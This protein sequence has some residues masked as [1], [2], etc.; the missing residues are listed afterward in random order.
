MN[1]M[2]VIRKQKKM[3][4]KQLGKEVGVSESTISLY[5]NGKHEPDLIT[6]GRIADVLGVSVD[7]LLGRDETQSKEDEKFYL[8]SDEY[9]LIQCYRA[10][11]PEG[12][13]KVQ[14]YVSDIFVL[15]SSE[16]NQT[17]PTSNTL[18]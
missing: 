13:E 2:R 16:K 5:E 7:Q 15:Y 10:I 8:S 18:K 12:K 11:A 6:I 14:S 4:M 1:N 17:F 9:R 3:T